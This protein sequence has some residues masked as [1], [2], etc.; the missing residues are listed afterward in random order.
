MEDVMYFHGWWEFQSI[1]HHS[2]VFKNFEGS[3]SLWQ[4]F[5][6]TLD[7]KVIVLEPD[8]I[9]LCQLSGFAVVFVFL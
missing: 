3:I 4:E 5:P 6:G 8:V 7:H 1:C 9:S 2:N